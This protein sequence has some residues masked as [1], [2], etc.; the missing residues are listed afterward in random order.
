M[1]KNVET[2]MG[3]LGQKPELSYTK[4]KKAVCNFNVAVRNDETKKTIWKKVVVWERQAE[5]C[6]VQLKKGSDIFVCGQTENKSFVNIDGV[7]KSYEQ[8]TAKLVGFTNV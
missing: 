8:V 1:N 6:S 4:N 7:K 5:L 3:K 2:F